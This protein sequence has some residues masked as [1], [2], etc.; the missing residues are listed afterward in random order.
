MIRR[1]PRS[2]LFPYTTLFRSREANGSETREAAPKDGLSARLERD[3]E[4]GG[5]GRRLGDAARQQHLPGD[6][7]TLEIGRAHVCTPVTPIY[8][9][10]SSA[11]KKKHIAVSRI[12]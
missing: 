5:G 7:E 3:G 12:P 6:P 10:P 8:R 2:T 9:M 4:L 1:P 11:F